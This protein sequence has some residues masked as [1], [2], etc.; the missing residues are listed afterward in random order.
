LRDSLAPSC[1]FHKLRHFE[2]SESL[3][4]LELLSCSFDLSLLYL[5][6]SRHPNLSYKLEAKVAHFNLLDPL[7]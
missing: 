4:H 2:D 7:F 1:A 3:P 5:G 6:C